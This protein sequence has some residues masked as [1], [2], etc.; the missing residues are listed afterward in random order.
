MTALCPRILN[1]QRPQLAETCLIVHAE[2]AV[3]LELA[4]PV[5]AVTSKGARDPNL[6]VGNGSC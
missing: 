3:P 4:A 2:A 6:P 5:V 1:P